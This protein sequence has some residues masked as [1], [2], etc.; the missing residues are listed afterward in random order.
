M[1]CGKKSGYLSIW[2]GSQQLEKKVFLGLQ[3]TLFFQ[4]IFMCG[5]K[6][7][8]HHTNSYWSRIY[9]KTHLFYYL[10]PVSLRCKDTLTER[11]IGLF[12]IK[13]NRVFLNSRC[14]SYENSC[15]TGE[16]ISLHT[17]RYT[18]KWC[19]NYQAEAVFDIALFLQFTK[20]G[21]W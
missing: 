20:Y 7:A 13:I 19:P 15:C 14:D 10:S 5:L 3:E 17:T 2:E 16:K 18:G 12:K 21:C 6:I 4:V 9:Y 11:V 8:N 1:E